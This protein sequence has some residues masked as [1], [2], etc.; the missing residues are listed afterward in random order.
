MVNKINFRQGILSYRTKNIKKFSI[1]NSKIYSDC[2]ILL[3]IASRKNNF[4]FEIQKSTYIYDISNKNYG[5]ILAY[6]NHFNGELNFTYINK[7]LDDF[8]VNSLPVDTYP[9][10]IVFDTSVARGYISINGRSWATYDCIPLL[11]FNNNEISSFPTSCQVN[12]PSDVQY[13]NSQLKA[14]NIQKND[15]GIPLTTIINDEIN[16]V[17]DNEL[18]SLHQNSHTFKYDSILYAD[19]NIDKNRFVG[20]NENGRVVM[21]TGS[22][23]IIPL[24]FIDTPLEKNKQ[25]YS[26]N[27]DGIIQNIYYSLDPNKSVFLSEYG[28][29]TQNIN[30]LLFIKKIGIAISSTEILLT[31][32]EVYT[33]HED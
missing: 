13:K 28:E 23:S 10:N 6:I 25:L 2:N 32:D 4:I 16:F 19:E 22:N 1:I 26:W 17:E 20:I 15:L 11:Y 30:N 9:G 18:N 14:Y 33:L 29:L 12:I 7:T 31:L 27:T 21:A 5:L 24:G 3:T 8:Y